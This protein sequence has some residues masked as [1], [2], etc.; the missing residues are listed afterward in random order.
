MARNF[1]RS[2]RGR[3]ASSASSSTR[4]LKASQLSS[5]LM[6]GAGFSGHRAVS[7]A[8]ARSSWRIDRHAV[9]LLEQRALFLQRQALDRQ[10]LDVADRDDE[11]AGFARERQVAD[12]LHVVAVQ[13][14]RHPQDGGH[15]GHG[16]AVVAVQRRVLRMRRAR[17][18]A[19]VVAGHQRDQGHVVPGQAEQVAVQDQ[20]HRV[21]V[22]AAAADEAADLVEERGDLEQQLVALVE[23]VLGL[24][25]AEQLHAE[26]RHV[27]AVLLVDPYFSPSAIAEWI[28]CSANEPVQY[29]RSVISFSRP[30]RRLVFGTMMQSALNARARCTYTSRAGPTVSASWYVRW[31][32]LAI[33]SADRGRTLSTNPA[34]VL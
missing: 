20:V 29:P 17:H 26:V 31:Y 8:C 15:L 21:L 18:G 10:V 33:R 22:V 13:R 30:S 25:L 16:D 4:R 12:L 2:S 9:D 1:S 27:P 28:T 14:V 19:A 24:K 5:R 32:L 7:S 34:K 3:D 23:L 11:L 6:N